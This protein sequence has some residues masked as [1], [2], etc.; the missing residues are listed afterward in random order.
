VIVNNDFLKKR[1]LEALK[2]PIS[3]IKARLQITGIIITAINAWILLKVYINEFALLNRPLKT[4]ISGSGNL[5]LALGMDKT[6][7]IIH[8]INI[9]IMGIFLINFKNSIINNGGA[10]YNLL[11]GEFN[12]ERG[13]MVSIRDHDE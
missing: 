3:L 10:T 1:S 6:E 5:N 2:I 13:F 7:I 8:K 12:P 4:K 9:I 11:T